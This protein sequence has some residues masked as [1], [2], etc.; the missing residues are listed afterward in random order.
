MWRAFQWAVPFL[1][2]SDDCRK[3]FAIFLII[4]LSGAML[5]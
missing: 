5:A 1:E 2:G 4:N 3:F